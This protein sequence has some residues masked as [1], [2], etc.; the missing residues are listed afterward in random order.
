MLDLPL[1][2]FGVR[3]PGLALILARESEHLVRH[4][5]AIRLS[6]RANS[7]G[8]QQHVDATAG[9]QIKDDLTRL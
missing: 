8:R 9:T 5:Q 7:F 2:E 4:V 6:G 1:Q 3:D